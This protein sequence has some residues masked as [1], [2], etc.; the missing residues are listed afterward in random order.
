M[1]NQ[2]LEVFD[3]NISNPTDSYCFFDYFISYIFEDKTESGT[4][5]DGDSAFS[6]LPSPV[7]PDSVF[8]FPLY[9]LFTNSEL[10]NSVLTVSSI[11]SK[12]SISISHGVPDSVLSTI[13]LAPPFLL[14]PFPL[15][16]NSL[17]SITI[18]T[19]QV[20]TSLMDFINNL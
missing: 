1:L 20:Q 6:I 4:T 19:P 18:L 17:L 13:V 10:S 5:G 15:A 7:V 9:S 14:Y 12:Y 3:T 8:S 11:G 16:P 2:I